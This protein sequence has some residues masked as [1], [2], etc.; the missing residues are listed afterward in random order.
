MLRLDHRGPRSTGSFP[1]RSHPLFGGGNDSEVL[2]RLLQAGGSHKSSPPS[3]GFRFPFGSDGRLDADLRPHLQVRRPP[4]GHHPML[5]GGSVSFWCLTPV[6]IALALVEARAQL[7]LRCGHY[8]HNSPR[9]AET[10]LHRAWSSL[11]SL[12]TGCG[13]HV[14]SCREGRPEGHRNWPDGDA[15]LVI[16]W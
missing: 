9:F 4:P 8:L 16:N 6:C 13:V 11:G 10:V 5:L 14:G 3:S 7:R 15:L 2:P 12:E 1:K